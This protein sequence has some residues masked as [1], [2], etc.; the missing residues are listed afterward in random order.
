MSAT[1]R[2]EPDPM[3]PE[4]LPTGTLLDDLGCPHCGKTCDVCV[5]LDEERHQ[6]RGAVSDLAEANARIETLLAAENKAWRDA[7]TWKER[8]IE[9]GWGQS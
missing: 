3:N 9:S 6:L 8:A 4:R 2:D 1:E 5:V 7:Q